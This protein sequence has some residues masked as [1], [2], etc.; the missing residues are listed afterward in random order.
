MKG[1]TRQDPVGFKNAIQKTN[2]K[3]EKSYTFL[4]TATEKSFD[5][6]QHPFMIKALKP[7]IEGHVLRTVNGPS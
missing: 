7:R 4:L 6:A 5:D 2:G 3:K 1:P